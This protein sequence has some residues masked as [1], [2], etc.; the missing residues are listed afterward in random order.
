[1]KALRVALVSAAL[2]FVSAATGMAQET[3][4]ITGNAT[5]YNGPD[6]GSGVAGSIPANTAVT[7]EQCMATF[8]LVQYGRT[9]VWVEAQYIGQVP[10]GQPA[11]PPPQAPQQPWPQPQPQP[12]E[13][14]PWPQPQPEPP[15]FE[16]SAGAC[17]YSERNFRG[18]SFCVDEGDSYSRLRNWNDRIRSVEIFGGARV[19]LCTDSN[20]RGSCVTLR[21]D[22]SRLP[23]EIDRRTSSI[24]VY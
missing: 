13:P 12:Q 4:V 9:Q 22:T 5:T 19:D 24:D 14:W 23:S 8:C 17:F 2:M 3:V 18:S 20:Y 6:Y 7:M 1:M 16:E 21:R 11:P 15:V 10:A